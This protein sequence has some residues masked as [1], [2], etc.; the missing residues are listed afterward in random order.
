MQPLPGLTSHP[1]VAAVNENKPSEGNRL[2][3][4][5]NSD[6]FPPAPVYRDDPASGITA[7]TFARSSDRR[8]V[9]PA[10]S[11]SS[12]STPATTESPGRA[13]YYKI[14]NA[15]V[16]EID[17]LS[18]GSGR[19]SVS[20]TSSG[21]GDEESRVVELRSCLMRDFEKVWVSPVK[22]G[23]K[24]VPRNEMESTCKGYIEKIERIRNQCM[25]AMETVLQAKMKAAES[26]KKVTENRSWW[27]F[28]TF[29]RR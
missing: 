2:V 21:S 16:R 14:I 17:T 7:A 13:T 29:G 28:L 1:I 8:F 22:D 5:E 12:F 24:F 26:E 25:E 3:K 6:S 19:N 15:P 20:T 4:P 23:E 10:G 9:F 11:D 27:R 18:S